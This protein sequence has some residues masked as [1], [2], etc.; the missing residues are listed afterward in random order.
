MESIEAKVTD[1]VE[2]K[3]NRAMRKTHEIVKESYAILVNKVEDNK[4]VTMS[5]PPKE[6]NESFSH[7]IEMSFRVQ[8]IPEDPDKARDENFV[9]THEQVTHILKTIGVKAEI[10]NLRRLGKFQ[11]ERPKSRAVLVTL[12]SATAVNL[13]MAK[14]VERQSEVKDMKFFVPRALSIE[15]SRKKKISV[16]EGI[17]NSLNIAL[18]G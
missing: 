18:K 1:L 16:L 8:G 14:S 15:D 5:Q 9:Q 12:P 6:Q 4:K 10:V 13:L 11:K 7:N 17:R 3:I 2:K